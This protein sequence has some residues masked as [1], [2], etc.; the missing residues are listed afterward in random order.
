MRD[1]RYAIWWLTDRGLGSFRISR[2]GVHLISILVSSYIYKA[3]L[4]GS[5]TDFI[6]EIIHRKF[7]QECLFILCVIVQPS[8]RTV[9]LW[10]GT[11]ACGYHLAIWRLLIARR[12]VINAQFSSSVICVIT[13][14]GKEESSSKPI[15]NIQDET[16][17]RFFR[18]VH[19]FFYHRL[20]GPM[21]IFSITGLCHGC[22]PLSQRGIDTCPCFFMNRVAYFHCSH[23]TIRISN[24]QEPA[25]VYVC[26]YSKYWE[27][28]GSNELLPGKT[29]PVHLYPTGSRTMFPVPAN[30]MHRACTA[31]ALICA[32]HRSY[33]PLVKCFAGFCTTHS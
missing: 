30:A 32:S 9:G 27:R 14:L 22:S 7:P 13:S 11:L 1:L 2:F 33:S 29:H 26:C 5:A 3:W 4:V 31:R 17:S 12:C 6:S 24:G 21:I 10:P 19:F 18:V 15:E 28:S 8:W 20:F 25:L 16:T 23:R